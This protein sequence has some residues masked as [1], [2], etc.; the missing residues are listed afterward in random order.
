MA[1]V[2]APLCAFGSSHAPIDVFV[3]LRDACIRYSAG[4]CQS[5]LVLIRGRLLSRRSP[6]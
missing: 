5:I 3:V 1:V 4:H 6:S 2:F